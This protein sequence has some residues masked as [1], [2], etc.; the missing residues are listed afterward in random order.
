MNKV[1][2]NKNG[3]TLVEL[4]VVMAVLAII[5]AIAVPRFLGVQDQAKLD[6]D[7]ATGAMIAKAAELYYVKEDNVVSPIT[8][9]D[10]IT[11]DYINGVEFK[12]DTFSSYTAA[13]V[14]ITFT[15]TGVVEVDAN[16]GVAA[17][18]PLY[19]RP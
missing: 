4:I 5:S 7:Y 2:K 1:L 12:S 10:L 9:S 18:V 13:T 19:P 6:A 14:Q 15:G 11:G 16:D 17:A 8:A 3:F